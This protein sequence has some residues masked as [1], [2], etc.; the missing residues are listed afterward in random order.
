MYHSASA[1]LGGLVPASVRLQAE[2]KRRSSIEFKPFDE[3]DALYEISSD[4]SVPLG[5]GSLLLSARHRQTS[6]SVSILVHSKSLRC[7]G[8]TRWKLAKHPNVMQVRE[9][10]HSVNKLYVVTD[11]WPKTADEISL[12]QTLTTDEFRQIAQ[13]LLQ[14]L[15]YLHEE[16][17]VADLSADRVLIDRQPNYINVFVPGPFDIATDELVAKDLRTAGRILQ[18]LLE[19]VNTGSRVHERDNISVDSTVSEDVAW[20]DTT[21]QVFVRYLLTDPEDRP[22]SAET[23]LKHPF[24]SQPSERLRNG[25]NS[26]PAMPIAAAASPNIAAPAKKTPLR[27]KKLFQKAVRLH[28]AALRWRAL[29]EASVAVEAEVVNA[30]RRVRSW[31]KHRRDR[32]AVYGLRSQFPTAL[33]VL[34]KHVISS[35]VTAADALPV[36]TKP[37]THVLTSAMRGRVDSRCSAA[38]AC[39]A[40][41]QLVYVYPNCLMPCSFIREFVLTRR[42]VTPGDLHTRLDPTASEFLDELLTYIDKLI[43]LRAVAPVQACVT[44]A[45][46]LVP[47]AIRGKDAD[48]A[49]LRLAEYLSILLKGP[50]IAIP[51]SI[52]ARA[53]TGRLV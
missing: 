42:P 1:R 48:V 4:V 28:I 3:V 2:E 25:I 21:A 41:L 50:P 20:T 47:C 9:V 32:T 46:L 12:R 14:A 18:Q 33:R 22:P 53:E 49:V 38:V 40:I 7:D 27:G 26:H 44:F 6:D 5:G 43:S 35:G 52:F 8:V 11:S 13:Q 19:S 17:C 45:S 23:M 30:L 51:K 24:L 16:D 15:A 34:C 36:P 31:I 39:D 10:L 37:P 29:T